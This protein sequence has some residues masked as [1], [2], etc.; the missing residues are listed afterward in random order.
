TDAISV[1]DTLAVI[2]YDKCIYCGQCA[3]VCPMNTIHSEK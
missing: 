3:N 2:D 1:V